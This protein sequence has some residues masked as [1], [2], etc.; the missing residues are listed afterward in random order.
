M[1]YLIGANSVSTFIQ[2]ILRKHLGYFSST[3]EVL[4][5]E[6]DVVKCR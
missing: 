3:W 6:D 4:W 5:T 2:R 1:E